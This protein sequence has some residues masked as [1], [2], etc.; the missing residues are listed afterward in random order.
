MFNINASSKESVKY[1]YSCIATSVG[2]EHSEGAAKTF[3]AELDKPWL[4]IIDNAD[5]PRMDLEDV[6]PGGERGVILVTT[7]NPN[8]R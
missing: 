7:R 1:S 2:R 5:N 3:L 4:L 6:F 8:N